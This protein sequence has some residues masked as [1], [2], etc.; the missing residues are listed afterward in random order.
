MIHNT[1][2]LLTQKEFEKRYP[3]TATN[4]STATLSW[5]QWLYYTPYHWIIPET[6]AHLYVVLPTVQECA[7]II[8]QRHYQKP[9]CSSLDNLFT[10]I[11]FREQYGTISC[12]QESTIQLSDLDLWLIL[13]YMHHHYGVAVADTVKTFG[14]SSTVIKFPERNESEKLVARISNNDKAI[15]NLK[16]A[17]STL[18]KQVT[19]L[20]RKSEE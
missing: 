11:E 4:P 1:C 14:A 10:F 20:Q 15:I 5:F 8:I 2:E 12:Y 9:L 16:T 7:K 17:C 3:V 19:D 6:P 13:R 18:H